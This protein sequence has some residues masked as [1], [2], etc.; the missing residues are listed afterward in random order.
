[1]SEVASVIKNETGKEQEV[2]DD[3][4]GDSCV[5]FNVEKAQTHG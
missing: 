1:M 3:G 4:G 2:R 5:D